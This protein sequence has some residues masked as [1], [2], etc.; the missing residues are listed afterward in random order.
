MAR[1][2]FHLVTD[3]Q[4][5]R[6]ECGFAHR[7]SA[8]TFI[9]GEKLEAWM[10]ITEVAIFDEFP[11]AHDFY[12]MQMRREAIKKLTPAERVALGIKE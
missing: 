2:T 10:E 6:I 5:G 9:V 12:L 8:E 7:I 1:R 3:R 4:T 11:E